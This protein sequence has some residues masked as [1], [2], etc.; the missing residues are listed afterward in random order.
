MDHVLLSGPPGLGKTTLATIIANEMGVPFTPTSAPAISKGA[1][2]GKFLTQL[3][4]K[5]V[6]F[7]DEIHG[8]QK[9]LEELLYPA[10]E[11]F[12]LDFVAGEA[13]TAQAIQIPLRPFTLVG[14]TTRSGIVS[15]PLRNRFGI[16]LKLD[17]YS[18]EE[19]AEV[20]SRSAGILNISLEEGIAHEIGKRSRKTP[21]IANHLLKRVRDFSEVAGDASVSFSTCELAFQRMGIDSLGLDSVDRQILKIIIERFRG[22]PVGLKP[23]SAI[24]G[25]EEKTI[26]DNYESYLVRIGLIDRTPQGRVASKKAYEHL[27]LEYNQKEPTLF[28]L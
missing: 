23:I 28:S 3:T 5:E 22:G 20:V 14:A 13:M 4:E 21:R 8:F 12:I 2:L 24:I 26:E 10:M 6:F 15:E 7:I 11:N 27:G 25:E 9:K 1:D 17:Y 18:E 19:M 16:H